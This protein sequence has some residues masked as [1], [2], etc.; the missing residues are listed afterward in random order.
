MVTFFHF[1]YFI[2]FCF[3]LFWSLFLINLLTFLS[4]LLRSCG[5]WSFSLSCVLSRTD[6]LSILFNT[7]YLQFIIVCRTQHGRT[8]QICL[9]LSIF[10]AWSI[11]ST[12]FSWWLEGW[13][14]TSHSPMKLISFMQVRRLGFEVRPWNMVED[15]IRVRWWLIR[16]I[17][18]V[19]NN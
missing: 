4:A 12:M 19:T 18:D 15:L 14:M 2:S 13:I 1:G 3:C 6:F 10:I 17:N 11:F 7:L 8:C 9:L 16:Y 5:L